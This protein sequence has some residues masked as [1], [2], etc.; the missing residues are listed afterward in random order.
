[1]AATNVTQEN[2][3][4]RAEKLEEEIQQQLN[5]HKE[6]KTSSMS[7]LKRAQEANQALLPSEDTLYSTS[8]SY[9]T[10]TTTSLITQDE[11]PTNSSN[12]P[13]LRSW[14]EQSVI[15]VLLDPNLQ[16]LLDSAELLKVVCTNVPHFQKKLEDHLGTGDH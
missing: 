1:M 16:E 8:I 2:D 4:R 7:I 11:K 5:T 14:L 9:Q 10:H 15:V 12:I 3:K 13:P 6:L